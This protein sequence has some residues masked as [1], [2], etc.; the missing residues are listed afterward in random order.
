MGP[1]GVG[2]TGNN[3]C[4]VIVMGLRIPRAI[5]KVAIYIGHCIAAMR[6]TSRVEALQ[7]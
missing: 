1:V 7:V 3:F 5:S 4:D 6:G 2:L